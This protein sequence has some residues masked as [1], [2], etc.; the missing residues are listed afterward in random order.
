MAAGRLVL[1]AVVKAGRPVASGMEI[2]AADL[3]LATGTTR[4][5]AGLALDH[6]MTGALCGYKRRIRS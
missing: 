4:P 5:F 1:R 3:K 6:A 2:E